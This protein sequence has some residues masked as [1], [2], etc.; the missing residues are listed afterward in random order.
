[1]EKRLGA[2][3]H[4]ESGRTVEQEPVPGPLRDADDGHSD[5]TRSALTSSVL[6]V[7]E[8]ATVR[9]KRWLVHAVVRQFSR[10]RRLAGW[11]VGWEMT[12][13]PSNRKRN[14]WAVG[15]LEVQPTDRVL[16]VGFGP[17]I[18][19]R[20]L[21][22]RATK[23]LVYGID[24]SEVMV[25]Q[26]T[27]RNRMAVKQG[28]VELRLGSAADL[29]A[30]DDVFDKVLVVNNFGMWPDPGQRL[31]DIRGLMRSGGRLAIVSQPR[32]PG[33][34]AAT[35]R[36]LGWATAEQLRSAGFAEIRTE[37]LDLQPPAACV[38]ADEPR[39]PEDA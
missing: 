26:A 4:R 12:I 2:E 8:S 27:R 37:I 34:N 24:H 28:R 30:V 17:G 20:A 35:T 6:E 21:A 19:I 16:E 25:R 14:L 18:A 10:P 3:M 7:V 32:S 5:P 36:R 29:S 39:C 9:G 15:L 38:L 13:R 11:L 31:K 22:G 23:G 1:M 33:A